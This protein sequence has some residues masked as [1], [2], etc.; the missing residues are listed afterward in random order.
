MKTK[1]V[2]YG[3]IRE[4]DNF[5]ANGL[6]WFRDIFNICVCKFGKDTYFTRFKNEEKVIKIIKEK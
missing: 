4:G 6:F 1:K 2:F 5:Y 3:S